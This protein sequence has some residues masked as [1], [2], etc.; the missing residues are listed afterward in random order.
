MLIRT[1]WDARWG[2]G[3]Y[4]E[5]GPFLTEE[6]AQLLVGA[7]ARIVGVDFWNV[8]EAIASSRPVRSC[9]LEGGIPLVENLANLKALPRDGFRFSAVPLRIDRGASILV[10]AFAEADRGTLRM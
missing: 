3:S 10:R 7:G 4:L 1:G 6:A 8:D 5:A 9:L 2:T